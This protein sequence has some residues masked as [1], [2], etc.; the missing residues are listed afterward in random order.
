MDL[1]LNVRVE[2][3]TGASEWLSPPNGMVLAE[4]LI[5]SGTE[6]LPIR[7]APMYDHTT[8]DEDQEI[9]PYCLPNNVAQY[10]AMWAQ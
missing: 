6:P 2:Q 5:C 8:Y 7:T 4:V 10:T 3:P 9:D 1:L